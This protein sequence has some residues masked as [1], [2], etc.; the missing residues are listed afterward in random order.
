MIGYFQISINSAQ[1]WMNLGSQLLTQFNPPLVKGIYPPDNSLDKN[2]LSMQ[3]ALEEVRLSK[4][5]IDRIV[6]RLKSLIRRVEKA[7][8]EVRLMERRL[9]AFRAETLRTS[10]AAAA[11]RS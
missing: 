1:Q 7:E 5:Q 6:L 3:R 8:N 10:S 11:R 9:D 4:K 2:R